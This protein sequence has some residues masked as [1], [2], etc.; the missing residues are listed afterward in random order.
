M[1]KTDKQKIVWPK[2]ISRL[3]R[4]KCREMI[5]K[6]RDSIISTNAIW[7]GES[8]CVSCSGGLD[9]TVLA[10]ILHYALKILGNNEKKYLCYINHKL[11]PHQNTS[12]IDFVYS[13]GQT[14]NY[15]VI[16]KDGEISSSDNIQFA[17]HESRYDSLKEV[18]KTYSAKILLAHHMD[19]VAESKLFQFLTGRTV[20]GMK[21]FFKEDDVVFE[22][23]LL[24]LCKDDIRLFAKAWKIS[25]CED[26]SNSGTKYTRNKIRHN[27]IPYI[28]KNIN[29]GFVKMLNDQL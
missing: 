27:L 26:E 14:L 5:N 23:P 28:Q 16:I 25:W 20:S 8:Y 7:P 2:N 29:P 4:V 13:I 21:K 18:A 11:R 17:A 24:S 10:Y 22:R 9:S 19:D 12:E 1:K 15:E 3:E 6:V